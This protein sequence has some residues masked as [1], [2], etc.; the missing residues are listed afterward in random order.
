MKRTR[1]TGL[2]DAT[3]GRRILVNCRAGWITLMIDEIASIIAKH[4]EITW[5]II[6]YGEITWIIGEISRQIVEH[7]KIP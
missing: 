4:G 2:P 6:K 1:P 3:S 5:V 7:G